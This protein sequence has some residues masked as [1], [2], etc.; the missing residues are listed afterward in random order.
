[1]GAEKENG[2]GEVDEGLRESWE[3]RES[4]SLRVP[5]SRRRERISEVD[6]AEQRG[7]DVRV[8]LEGGVRAV[9]LASVARLCGELA[10]DVSAGA[11]EEDVLAEYIAAFS[12]V[13]PGRR[14][15]V[16]VV[17]PATGVVDLVRSTGRLCS[18]PP[19]RIRLTA[20]ALAV[21]NLPLEMVRRAGIE[22]VPTYEADLAE[23]A[24]GCDA[25]L[26]ADGVLYGTVGVEYAPDL[27]K[28]TGDDALVQ[29]FATQ[30]AGSLARSRARQEANYLSGYVARLLDHANVPIVVIDRHR[31]VQVV[32]EA[33]LRLV[34]RRREDLVG[35]DFLTLVPESEQGKLLPALVAAM[36]GR[37]MDGFEVSLVSPDG[38]VSRLST[39]LVSVLGADG[40]VEGVIAIGRDLTELRRL[41]GQI[42]QAEKLATLGQLAAGVVHELNNPLTSISVYA[43]YLLQKHQ[44]ENAEAGDVEK[45]R[46][47]VQASER[48]LR[49]TRDLV[50]YARP[51]TEEPRELDIAE[52]LDQAVV[53]C[54]HVISESSAVVTK[55]YA[56]VPMIHG[57]RG[58]LHQVFINL[59]TNACHAMPDGAG[60]LTLSTMVFNDGVEVRL[61]DNGAGIPTDQLDT[62]FEPFYST[63]GEGKGT[64]LGLSIVRKIV[65]QHGGRISVQSLLGDGTTFR[66]WLPGA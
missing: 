37:A 22:I 31:K 55:T 26:V 24:S 18:H 65:Q 34:G 66:I 59:V 21:A 1:L 39:N 62:I 13:F 50:T 54:E 11:D 7:S 56:E 25:P 35:E 61:K 10:L 6:P 20:H 30:L 28:P 4:G 51:A 57:V 36:R 60:L 15:I 9:D 46:R 27:A 5:P 23:D 52:V 16:R 32:S 41:E 19:E 40:V 45:L 8:G 47:I 2:D 17:D 64:G 53:F 44:N 63:K 38:G 48:I 3:K 58:Q 33:L 42:V 14:L 49:F 29:L 12:R 43:E